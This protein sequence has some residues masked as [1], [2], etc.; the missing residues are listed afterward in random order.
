MIR[1][2]GRFAVLVL[3]LLVLITACAG[4]AAPSAPTAAAS[5]PVFAPETTVIVPTDANTTVITPIPNGTTVD[6][7]PD[8]G[9]QTTP[10]TAGG[11]GGAIIPPTAVPGLPGTLGTPGACEQPAGWFIY[12]V[13]PG[14]ILSDLAQR[15]GV[16]INELVTANCLTDPDA[17]QV[18][19]TL[20]LPPSFQ[21]TAAP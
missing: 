1:R 16:E 18:G 7:I 11:S 13:Q 15:S 4:N 19:Q 14:D 21:L 20:F 2:I 5:P 12:T 9:T 8:T 3:P 10:N 17:I 6:L